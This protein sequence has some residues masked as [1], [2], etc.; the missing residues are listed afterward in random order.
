MAGRH[1]AVPSG[2]RRAGRGTARTRTPGLVERDRARLATAWLGFPIPFLNKT[3]ELID[4]DIGPG[5]NDG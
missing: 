2:H 3:L 1:D 5:N 4:D